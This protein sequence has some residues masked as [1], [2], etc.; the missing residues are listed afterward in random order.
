M[1]S[2]YLLVFFLLFL[3]ESL[4]HRS[5]VKFSVVFLKHFLQVSSLIPSNMFW[6]EP[7]SPTTLTLNIRLWSS[8]ASQANSASLAGL[9]PVIHFLPGPKH[10]FD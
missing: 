7:C 6:A 9:A 8:S 10:W 1:L 4:R 3:S 2:C 5:I